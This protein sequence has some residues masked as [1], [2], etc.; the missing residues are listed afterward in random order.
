[1][2]CR[3]VLGGGYE[4]Y[5]S[6]RVTH[7]IASQLSA[8]RAAAERARRAPP[9]V[10]TGAWVTDSIAAR[11]LLPLA[12]YLLECVALPPGQRRLPALLPAPAQGAAHAAAKEARDACAMLQAAP[13]SCRE[14]PEFIQRYYGASRLHFIG[15]WRQRNA[16]LLQALAHTGP[17][18]VD[19][20][21][22]ERLILHVDMD[23]FFASVVARGRPELLGVPLAV[24][25]SASAAGSAE[26]SCA[27]YA[28]RAAGVHAGQC[29][30]AAMALCPAL[31]VMPYDF[32]AF[33]EASEQLYT[34]LA[35]F[36]RRMQP[37]SVD[38]AFLD[39]TGLTD[40]PDAL[41]TAVRDAVRA[42][43]GGC[44]A[45]VGIAPN[46]LLAKLATRRAKPAGQFRLRAAEAAAFLAPMSIAALPGVGRSVEARL[47]ALNIST[48]AALAAADLAALQRSLGVVAG[49]KLQAAAQGLDES[50][51]ELPGE[52]DSIG[53][54]CSWGVRFQTRAEADAFLDGLA[55]EVASRLREDGRAGRTLTLK[56]KRSRDVTVAPS[57]LLGCGD[58]DALSR[59]VRF[60]CATAAGAR[61]AD[62]AKLLLNQ[63]SI[64]PTLLR[65]LGISV[66]QLVPLQ[67]GAR[68][69]GVQPSVA[70]ALGAGASGGGASGDASAAAPVALASAREYAELTLTQI[71]PDTWREL[72]PAVQAELR[73]SLRGGRTLAAAAP[74]VAAPPARARGATVPAQVDM[75]VFDALPSDVQA[76]LRA[77][78]AAEARASGGGTAGKPRG[79][80]APP[81][82]RRGAKGGKRAKAP[83]PPPRPRAPPRTAPPP[84]ARPPPPR[85]PEPLCAALPVAEMRSALEACVTRRAAL[86][87][88]DALDAAAELLLAH[89]EAC[90]AAHDLA[91]AAALL[92]HARRLAARTPA[93]RRHCERAVAGAQ[94]AVA[95]RYDTQLSLAEPGCRAS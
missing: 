16:R 68:S 56:A 39:V 94:R 88:D 80:K 67:E 11:H 90:V 75:S 4:Q 31:V 92:R 27:N 32:D 41:A 95:A 91:A 25:H 44:E 12:P 29:M 18:P 84:E 89:C 36:S 70:D 50:A 61:I 72:T 81:P 48:V 30:R 5:P 42:A 82:R 66:S 14:D 21:S 3:V 2:F 55:Q 60:A 22:H 46:K 8:S 10:V 13:K 40:A 26:V 59:S 43:T 1:V 73:A 87:D 57:K 63:L 52:R 86:S 45:S 20:P 85:A 49:A 37:V 62:E 54:E 15:D 6:E 34:A 83:P 58:C 51:V 19:T 76:E 78:W 38:E 77:S 24:S 7:V 23:C 53:A 93:W 28:A 33:S 35:S 9:P 71:A 79:G 65:G 17:E 64:A 74:A 47:V 69:A